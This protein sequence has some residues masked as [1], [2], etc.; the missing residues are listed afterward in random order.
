M[1]ADILWMHNDPS[2]YDKLVRQRGWTIAQFRDWLAA[3]LQAQLL[4]C[5]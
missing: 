3:A 1:A 2:V 4:G 5:A